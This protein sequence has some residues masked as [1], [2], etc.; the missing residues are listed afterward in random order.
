MTSSTSTT[1]PAPALLHCGTRAR[2]SGA[3]RT[4]PWGTQ[5]MTGPPSR[6]LL[7][8]RAG[9]HPGFYADANTA[10]T[11]PETEMVSGK[12]AA[13]STFA[14]WLEGRNGEE[15]RRRGRKLARH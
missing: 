2:R 14:T 6:A 9:K 8:H 13:P 1:G 7:T 5:D 10:T 4:K 12:Q 15:G 3:Q 11:R